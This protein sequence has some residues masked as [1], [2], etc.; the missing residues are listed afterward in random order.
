[1]DQ[2]CLLC[3]NFFNI[4]KMLDCNHIFCTNCIESWFDNIHESCPI[5]RSNNDVSGSIDVINAIKRN[6]KFY[7]FSREIRIFKLKIS[8][9]S[10]FNCT[11]VLELDDCANIIDLSPI[12]KNRLNSPYSLLYS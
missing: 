1:M 5:C 10:L 3:C 2:T 9:V 8:D 7:N 12:P 4:P 11:K 6:C